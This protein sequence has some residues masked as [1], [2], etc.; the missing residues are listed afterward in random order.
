M[1]LNTALGARTSNRHA[2]ESRLGADQD[3]FACLLLGLMRNYIDEDS[4][5]FH[6]ICH[7]NN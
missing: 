2:V 5:L 6:G 7:Y 1:Y 3:T 4:I